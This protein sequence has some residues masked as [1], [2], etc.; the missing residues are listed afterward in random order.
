MKFGLLYEMQRPHE[1]YKVDYTALIEETL[2]QCQLAD[3][4]GFDYLWFVEHHFLTTFSGSSAPEVIISALARLTKRIRLGFGVVILGNHRPTQVAERVAMVDH[5]SGGR[6]EFGVGRSSP[7]E[8]LGMG[9]D[10][11]DTRELMEESLR[12]VPEIW[13]TEGN[14]EWEGKFYDIPPREILPKPKQDPHPPIWMACTQ[15]SSYKM[16]AHHGVGVLSFGSG[17]PA[18]MKQHVDKY[19]EDIKS[20]EPVGSAINNQWASFTLGHCGDNNAEAQELGAR[21]I[22][23]FFGPNRP[24][25]SDRQET[26][27][28]LLESWGGVP[29]HLQTNFQRFLGGE[30][31]L[32]GGGVPRAMLGELPA[33]LLC[34]RGVIVAG[35]PDSCINSVRRHEEIG[36]DQTL[37]IMQSDQIPHK[38]V[39]RSI[40]LFG[41]QV[42]PAF[43]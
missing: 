3:E 32:G 13:R 36:A 28:R 42:I 37:L 35:D 2:E 30:Q 17:A 22:K 21:A 4:V 40:K 11:R 23:E 41:E 29:E 12:M 18:G 1:D 43:E 31:D 6:V 20:A 8:Q 5:L 9:V 27:E 19:R 25:S 7:Y 16:A 38:K 14:F 10:P 26:Y 33:D 15:P 24:Y 39:M 34:E